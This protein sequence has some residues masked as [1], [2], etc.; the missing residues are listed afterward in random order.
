MS[1]EDEFSDVIAKAMSGLEIET[2]ELAE[3]A[4]VEVSEISGLL[5]GDLSAA[6]V[7]KICPVLGLDPDAL[8]AL[9]N[10][11]PKP[12]AIP[13][14]T[15]IELPFRQWTV[16]AWLVE[17]DGTRL[18]FDTGFGNRDI[19]RKADMENLA[20][21]FIT[22]DHPDHIG[23]AAALDAAGATIIP[24]AA[25]KKAGEFIFGKLNIRVV[26]LAGHK[27]PA[28]GYFIEGLERQ[29]LVVGD[30]LFAGSMGRC[31]SR[32]SYDL[33]FDT[34]NSALSEAEADC[35]ILPGHGPAT[36]LAEEL[37]SNP[38]K[39]RFHLKLPDR[40]VIS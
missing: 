9:P 11:L 5:Q 7:R 18:L 8:L 31:H 17:M 39:P 22:H 6:V 4:G 24:V 15:R 12:L 38:F 40:S 14:I 19:F 27:D 34:I 29:L 3:R 23:G 10:Y 21:V 25:A 13:G 30:A 33:A 36:T 37:N 20:S 35:V 28:A 26:D 2:S 32:K 16:N 1:L